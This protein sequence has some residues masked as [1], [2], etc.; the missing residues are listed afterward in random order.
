MGGGLLQL[1]LSGQQDQYIIHN[2]QLSYFKYA[3]KKHTNFSMESIPLSFTTKPLMFPNGDQSFYI[4]NI[5]RHGD[6]LSN[7][8]F[9]F[10]LPAIYSADKYKF[11]WVENIGNMLIKKAT[12]N[13]GGVV[14]DSLTG[15]WLSI[16]NELSLK[17]NG[18]YNRLI[19]NVPE[20]ISPTISTPRIG[21]KNNKFYYTFY[22][23]STAGKGPP[24]INSK[25]LYVPLNF[26][27]TRNPALA[28]PLLKLQL[29]DIYVT[30]WT[31]SS[32]DL[33]Q[34]Y[35]DIVDT[36]VSPKYY[37]ILHNDNININTF[38]STI[39]L[40]AYIDA[41]YIFLANAERDSLILMTN[42]TDAENKKGMQYIVEQISTT[43]E[44][45]VSAKSSARV[46]IELNN[47][48]HTKE[49]IWTVRRDDYQKYNIFNNY[50][51]SQRYN[52]YSKIIKSAEIIWNNT[53]SRIAKDADYFS[54]LQPYQHHTN[55]PR[56]GI[57]CYSFA[58][59]PEKVN[60]TGSYN[61]AVVKTTLRLEVDGQY[62]N[63]DINE[64]LRLL[65]KSEYEFDYL[66]NVYCITMNVFEIIG[67]QGS[68]KFS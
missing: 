52:E 65:K 50:T 16:W 2:P 59:F 10:T 45:K 68:M 51:A 4:C 13:I 58:L 63:E 28:L 37:N 67:G 38:A 12:V 15:E 29:S 6:L 66:V 7:L 23:F 60:P 31:N 30:I 9:C 19:G 18:S 5:N 27:F 56:S 54:Y 34:V 41:N 11:R 21:I 40:N 48:R 42:Y 61:G 57:Y 46:D 20:L 32:E 17:D 25:T 22:P 55:V 49:I 26:W 3:Y 53:N 44:T 62:K 1:V 47:H 39:D 43:T 64:K 35:S 33:Y 14:I 24:S 36:Y 8:Y